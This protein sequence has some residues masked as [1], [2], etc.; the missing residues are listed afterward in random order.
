M[1]ECVKHKT[2]NQETGVF[3]HLLF[4]ILVD[5]LFSVFVKYFSFQLQ[6]G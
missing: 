2:F 3:V 1:D 5:L 4:L 6:F